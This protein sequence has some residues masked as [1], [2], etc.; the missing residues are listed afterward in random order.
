MRVSQYFEL[1]RSQPTLDFVDVDIAT[2][3][4]VFIS[5]RAL[6]LLPSSWGHECVPW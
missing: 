4:P 2:D 6:T 5:P 3:I 1:G